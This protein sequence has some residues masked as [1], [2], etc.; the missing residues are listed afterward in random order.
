[1]RGIR[2]H[3]CQ[4]KRHRLCDWDKLESGCRKA[5]SAFL[6]RRP[7]NQPPRSPAWGMR[8]ACRDRGQKRTR[9]PR[10]PKCLDGSVRCISVLAVAALGAC[11]TADAPPPGLPS[12]S[13]PDEPTTADGAGEVDE[14]AA[15]AVAT[16]PGSPTAG[17]DLGPLPPLNIDPGLRKALLQ[18]LTKLEEEA[19]EQLAEE[20]RQQGSPELVRPSASGLP[21]TAPASGPDTGVQVTS[22]GTSGAGGDFNYFTSPGGRPTAEA[23]RDPE[24]VSTSTTS[25][26]TTTT[27]TTSTTALPPTAI[28]RNH[29]PESEPA[30]PLPFNLPAS[31]L[32]TAATL[33][34]QPP[35]ARASAGIAGE[36]IRSNVIPSSSSLVQQKPVV[37]SELVKSISTNLPS[38]PAANNITNGTT[39]GKPEVAIFQAPLVAAFTL[40]HDLTGLP[41]SVEPLVEAPVAS[42][43]A[44]Q[45]QLLAVHQRHVFLKQQRQKIDELERQRQQQQLFLG[46]QPPP[47][48]VVQQQQAFFSGRPTLQGFR[49]QRQEQQSA[50]ANPG[51]VDVLPSVGAELKPP[52]PPLLRNNNNNNNNN[53]AQFRGFSPALSQRLPAFLPTPAS[54]QQQVRAQQ[55]QQQQQL[56]QSGTSPVLSRQVPDGRGQ[57]VLIQ[58][59]V[60]F[61][62]PVQPQPQDVSFQQFPQLGSFQPGPQAFRPQRQQPPPPPFGFRPLSPQQYDTI[63]PALQSL[64]RQQQQQQ[65]RQ[66]P[67]L[68]QNNVLGGAL[69]EDIDIVSKVLSLNHQRRNDTAEE[70]EPSLTP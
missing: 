24:P 38:A 57:Q 70:E 69:R 31:P 60:P 49:S 34:S 10:S 15:A 6:F 27:T 32:P 13:G 58:Q 54:P 25:T 8:D 29:R 39:G 33:L 7:L 12:S 28:P 63:T 68:L 48:S 47:P 37:T 18:A 51:V 45:Q 44:F 20:E 26:T 5:N 61:S 14:K 67:S 52:P 19:Q 35:S 55:Q 66:R 2:Q 21:G 41:Q 23:S 50:T 53:A 4:R 40:H 43:I 16:A 9:V 64:Q 3:G 46:Q 59:S 36:D 22:R 1:M 62:L 42:P 30:R 11:L 56:L 17:A 65:F